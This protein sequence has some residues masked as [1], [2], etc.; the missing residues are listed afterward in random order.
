MMEKDTTS[1]PADHADDGHS[2]EI[3]RTTPSVV[4]PDSMSVHEIDEA[5]RYALEL[6]RSVR[7][8]TGSRQIAALDEATAVGLRPQRNAGRQL[9]LMNTRLGSL[10]DETGS[11]KAIATDLV[12]LRTALGRLDPH[13]GHRGLA[14]R[15]VGSVPFLRNRA[16]VRRL[17]KIAV[18]HEPIS[19]QITVVETRLREGR[20]LLARD[21]VELRQL[22][23]DVES[24]QETIKRQTFTAEVLL[25]ELTAL[26]E[27]DDALERDRIQATMHDVATRVQDLYTMQE[28]HLQ[29]FVSIELTRQNNNRLGQAVDRTITLATNV[30]TV[31]LAIQSALVRQRNV[32]EA[33]ERTREFLGEMV[34]QNAAAIRQQTD[35]IGDLYTEPVIAMDKLQQAH[36]DLLAALDAASR[37]RDQGL[38]TARQNIDHLKDLT[39]ELIEHVDGSVALSP[40]EAQR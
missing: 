39:R 30:V 5:H 37:L 27:T 9:E 22:Y 33:T 23:E 17:T 35:S 10:L 19:K 36:D 14:A 21:N 38:Q 20:R 34:A 32:K 1:P 8:S 11:A 16:L 6:V 2:V 18:R 24:Q 26:E 40:S 31:G 25:H 12:D 7:E 28:V 4:P 15:T 29:Y 13:F 3:V